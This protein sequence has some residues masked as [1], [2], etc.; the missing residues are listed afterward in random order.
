MTSCAC[1]RWWEAPGLGA[2]Y[3]AIVGGRPWIPCGAGVEIARGSPVTA[4]LRGG[5][6]TV[7]RWTAACR[8]GGRVAALH[9]NRT[10]GTR[11]STRSPPAVHPGGRAFWAA[12][13]DD[14]SRRTPPAQEPRHDTAADHFRG[15]AVPR[16]HLP[17]ARDTAVTGQP[18][19]ILDAAQVAAGRQGHGPPF[20]PRARRTARRPGVPPGRPGSRSRSTSCGSSSTGRSW[21]RP[22]PSGSSP[23]SICPFGGIETIVTF[24]TAGVFVPARALVEPGARRSRSCSSRS[25]A[26]GAF[27]G[28]ICPLGFLQDLAAGLELVRPAP[29]AG[30]VPRDACAP[31]PGRPARGPRPPA[32]AP[33]VRGARLGDLG[34]RHVRRDGLPGRRPLD[35]PAGHRPGEHRLRD[36]RAGPD[37]WSGRC[38]WTVPGAATPVRSAPRMGSSPAS[39]RSASSGRRRRAST[40]TC[41]PRAARWAS[42][43]R[44]RSSS[45]RPTASAASSAWRPA[46]APA[47]SS[48]TSDSRSVAGHE[49]GDTHD[50]LDSNP[51]APGRPLAHSAGR[52]RPD[53]GRGLRGRYRPRH[54]QRHVPDLGQDHGERRARRAPRARPSPRSRAGWRSATSRPPG[55]CPLPELLAAFE[56]P[57]DTAPATA[58]KDLESDLFSVDGPAGLARRPWGCGAVTHRQRHRGLGALGS[59]PAEPAGINGGLCHLCALRRQWQGAT[60]ASDRFRRAALRARSPC[61][62][63]AAPLVAPPRSR[64]RPRGARHANTDQ[65]RNNR[66]R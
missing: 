52:L 20:A 43:S 66:Q 27:C 39:A 2:G 9:G 45:P 17:P 33:Q 44:R 54:G 53:R 62:W 5:R 34:N 36:G 55:A 41:A 51:S 4:R 6:P 18:I 24:L 32:A 64:A 47:P 38:S 21:P 37:C 65:G 42:T 31:P 15:P 60:V 13:P 8:S 28:W 7:R 56:L 29:R 23:E 63:P 19:A 14:R 25:S 30:R 35:R 10:L 59:E 40:A 11:I 48:S 22:A 12:P 49:H 58:L 61:E 46:R 50:G 57:A 3:E 16:G 26:R 1:A